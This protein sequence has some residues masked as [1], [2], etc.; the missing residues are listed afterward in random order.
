MVLWAILLIGIYSLICK[1]MVLKE[2]ILS[3]DNLLFE[4]E[5]FYNGIDEYTHMNNT[6][7][8][9]II[10]NAVWKTIRGIF[11]GK[12]TALDIAYNN[13]T[14]ERDCISVWGMK[15]AGDTG[16]E[17]FIHGKNRENNCFDAIAYF[18]CYKK[19]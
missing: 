1:G 12:L 9:D 11:P 17:V 18:E 10:E 5:V 16:T 15:T 7:Y 6:I 4:R 19:T 2:I 13:G 14:S 3:N 8:L